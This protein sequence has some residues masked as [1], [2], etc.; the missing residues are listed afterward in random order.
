M[1]QSIRQHFN[2]TQVIS[3]GFLTA[4]LSL[5][6]TIPS[7]SAQQLTGTVSQETSV[8]DTQGRHIENIATTRPYPMVFLVKNDAQTS[9]HKPH[10]LI[11]KPQNAPI[12]SVEPLPSSGSSPVNSL[13]TPPPSLQSNNATTQSL[14]SSSLHN[15]RS[16]GAAVP[17]ATMN[18]AP[19]P[20]TARTSIAAG[21]A[22]TGTSSL[23]AVGA[24]NTSTSGS[25]SSGGR[26]MSRL[27]AELPGLAQLITPPSAS[28]VSVNPAIGA[29]P[30]S[31][32]FTA[33][34][35]GGNP[36]TQ[37]LT[38]S[39]TGGGTLNWS[40]SVTNAPWLTLSRVS[41]AGNAAV[42]LTVA[43]GTLA[44]GPPLSG[45]IS[46]SAPG[47]TTVSVSVTLTVTAAPTLTMTPSSLAFTATQGAAN[48]NNQ[49]ISI[50]S[51]TSWTISKIGNWLTVN[52]TSGSNNGTITV[53]VNTATAAI[54]SN[55]ETIMVTG[56]GITRSVTVTL[57]LNAVATS[58][59]TLTWN[60]NGESD[61]AGYKI[62]RKVGSAGAY[63]LP[64]ATLQGNV[65]SYLTTGLLSGTTYSFVVTAYDSAGNESAVSNEVSKSIF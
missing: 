56:G 26:S 19:S 15:N 51:N 33:Q 49:T 34:Q 1:R 30:T 25:G 24:G 60:A 11:R 47:A 13:P 37:A 63:G 6:Q 3:F 38:I 65:M 9:T 31:L 5:L 41:G 22:S 64:I 35:G 42:T 4:L 61:L 44:A 7:V 32:S 39:N 23:A 40:A 8:T 16:V 18:V 43:T 50:T 45:M 17:L 21:I 57:T 59:A 20:A 48:P 36:A 14:E 28:V 12:V 55:P 53:S 46:I 54:G 27:A 58:S 62:Y 10:R 52:P 2:M 29:S